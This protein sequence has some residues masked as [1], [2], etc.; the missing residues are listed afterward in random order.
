[1]EICHKPKVKGRRAIFKLKKI[2][3]AAILSLSFSLPAQETPTP[4]PIPEKEL[5]QFCEIYNSGMDKWISYTPEIIVKQDLRWSQES[6]SFIHTFQRKVIAPIEG[7]SGEGF[8]VR[9]TEFSP[10]GLLAYYSQATLEDWPKIIYLAMPVEDFMLLSFEN[11]GILS[12]Q[13]SS[14]MIES[15]TASNPW[16]DV[17]DYL[18][19]EDQLNFTSSQSQYISFLTLNDPEH[20]GHL[21]QLAKS[22]SARLTSPVSIPNNSPFRRY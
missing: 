15:Q 16:V 2:L 11:P 8:S 5:Q 14:L 21:H 12:L 19:I 13:H 18:Q 9:I 1:L 10:Q 3:L 22:I 7:S 4:F 17:K 20:Y 6:L